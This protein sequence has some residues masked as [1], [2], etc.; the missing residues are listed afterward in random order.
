MTAL[1]RAD[2]LSARSPVL[3][4]NRR[5]SV[6]RR[7]AALGTAAL[8]TAL[9][10]ALASPALA[11]TAQPIRAHLGFGVSGV[12]DRAVFVQTD[13]AA[14]NEVVAYHRSPSGALTEA[15]SYQTRG[16]GGQLAGSVVDHLAS[17]G[18]LAVDRQAGLLVAVNAGSNTISVFGVRGDEL[19]LRQVASSGGTFPVS[20]SIHGD[21]A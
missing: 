21:L 12:N 9:V 13:N 6:R 7:A 4:V 8:G 15:G 18:S 10:A 11:A 3:G 2:S 1:N 16:L 17:Q 5:R 19:H 20:V 14:G